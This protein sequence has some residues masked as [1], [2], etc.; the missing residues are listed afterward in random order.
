M[1]QCST[2]EFLPEDRVHP[3][4]FKGSR[5]KFSHPKADQVA[6]NRQ[7]SFKSD[8][9]LRKIQKRLVNKQRATSKRLLNLGVQYSL[10]VQVCYIP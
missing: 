1:I 3:E 7:N 9:R 4:M 5:R 8:E 10:D 6:A 2:G